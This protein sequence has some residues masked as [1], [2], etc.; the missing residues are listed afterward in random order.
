MLITTILWARSGDDGVD[1]KLPQTLSQCPNVY[2]G[3]SDWIG[4]KR[5]RDV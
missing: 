4:I 2:F 5:I 1:K 3:S